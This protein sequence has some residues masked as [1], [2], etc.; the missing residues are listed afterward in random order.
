[1]DKERY[2]IN[3][4]GAQYLEYLNMKNKRGAE[5]NKKLSAWMKRNRAM[6]MV[7]GSAFMVW[8]IGDIMIDNAF[9]EPYA[10]MRWFSVY[11]IP[12]SDMMLV[13]LAVGFAAGL[14]IHGFA[15]VRR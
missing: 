6:L 4:T 12:V 9:R 11:G 3:W 1:M 14:A 5:F 2:I 13:I 7:W 10:P 15:V 8:C